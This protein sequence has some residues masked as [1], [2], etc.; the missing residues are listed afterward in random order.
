M[1]RFQ[2]ASY[3]L[4]VGTLALVGCAKPDAAPPSPTAEVEFLQ[5]NKTDP[6]RQVYE[7]DVAASAKAHAADF[8]FTELDAGGNAQKQIDQIKEA[9]AKKPKVLMV[10]PVSEA[11]L[12]E[13][14]AAHDA[15]IYVFL[16][17]MSDASTKA[18]TRVASRPILF[19]SDMASKYL[20]ELRGKGP[21]LIVPGP[22]SSYVAKETLA[23]MLSSIK[24]FAPKGMVH[25][26]GPDCN[27]S[28]ADAKAF[29]AQ[30]LA[31]K[32]PVDA[33]LAANDSMAIGAAEAVK[34]AG[35]KVKVF[36]S[37]GYQKA[38][39]DAL[40]DGSVFATYSN[41]PGAPQAMD[42]AADYIKGSKPP[43]SSEVS[44]DLIT[45]ATED[46]FLKAHPNYGQ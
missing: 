6:W 46:N 35:A 17:D 28:E 44:F 27:G 8:K 14:N 7:K 23:G 22:N 29:V 3:A 9:I 43:K 4:L 11:V 13:V 32:K 36:G 37:G 16:L 19:G 25:V 15:G 26:V 41:V 30:Y 20:G 5:A 10:S 1:N 2:V 42:F 34:A 45:K 40:R 24:R 33:I 21:V 38:I 31:S 18:D 12:P 39:F